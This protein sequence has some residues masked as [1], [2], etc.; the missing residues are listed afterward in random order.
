MVITATDLDGTLLSTDTT[1]SRENLE[2]I[3]RLSQK[4]IETVVVTGRGLYEIPQELLDFDSIEYFIC[5][6]RFLH[7]LKNS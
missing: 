7:L 4:G 3:K 1:V 6:H 5:I 2:A